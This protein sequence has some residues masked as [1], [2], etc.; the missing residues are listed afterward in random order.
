MLNTELIDAYE[1]MCNNIGFLL[2]TY[3]V[4]KSFVAKELG[5]GRTTLYERLDKNEF[6]PKELRRIGLAIRKHRKPQ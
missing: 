1:R 4:P 6:T 3:R 2:K 5:W